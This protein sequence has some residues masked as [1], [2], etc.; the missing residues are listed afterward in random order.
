MWFERRILVTPEHLAL[1]VSIASVGQRILAFFL[2][3]VFQVVFLVLLFLLL[4]FLGG[5]AGVD[6]ESMTA[7]FLIISFV[8]WNGY[9]LCFELFWQGRTPGK[10]IV[11]V[12]V[13]SRSGGPL[14][15]GAVM[16]RNLV[17]DL[18]FYLPIQALLMAG[19]DGNRGPAWATLLALGWLFLLLFLPLFNRDRAR[20]GDFVAGT[21]V[22]RQ[23]QATLLQDLSA[24]AND[25]AGDYAF[26]QEQLDVY[27]SRELQQLEG[28]LRGWQGRLA[29]KKR[30]AV[31]SRQQNIERVSSQ[32]REAIGWTNQV[33][34]DEHLNFLRAFYNAQRG[35]L[36]Q[37]LLM[38]ERRETWQVP[39][40]R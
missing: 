27:G 33:P 22:V 36:E 39:R 5:A 4:G 16:A 3:T 29:S 37:R 8:L 34:A 40:Q 13:I 28:V 23:P 24:V 19:L 1:T 12:R 30:G 21:L 14:T 2:D 11:Q 35:R 6:S 26:S 18:E 38:G 20:A 32:V 25:G 17:R 9:F 7:F 31:E 10:R 15:T